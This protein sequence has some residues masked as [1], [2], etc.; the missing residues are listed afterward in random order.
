MVLLLPLWSPPARLEGRIR[1]DKRPKLTVKMVREGNVG[2]R[3]P[4]R[5]DTMCHLQ[6]VPIP[7][8]APRNVQRY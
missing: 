2:K 1:P 5:I 6:S 3:L 8:P 4:I 7:T